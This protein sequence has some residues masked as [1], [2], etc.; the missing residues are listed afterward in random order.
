MLYKNFLKIFGL[1]VALL[2]SSAH[3]MTLDFTGGYRFEWTGISGPTLGSPAGDKTY[4]LN[5]LY[6]AP[7]IIAA[8]GINIVSRFDVLNTGGYQNS[9]LGQIWGMNVPNDG[10]S[11]ANGSNAGVAYLKMSQLY[12]SVEQEYGALL[13]GRV[14]IQF[15]L[16]M[17][18]N[19]GNGLFDHWYD[20]RDMVAYKIVLG[21]WFIMPMGGRIQS[22]GFYQG[23]TI[24]FEAA[25]VQ[26]E[27]KET[28]SS[29]GLMEELR[30]SSGTSNDLN[31]T[32]FGA[33][34]NGGRTGI[35]MQSTN[36]FLGRGFDNF[37][38]KLEAGFQSGNTGLVDVNGNNIKF[39][40]YGAA[41]ELN[42]PHP[43]SKWDFSGKLGMA[44]GENPNSTTYGA[45]QFSQN[46]DLGLL[47][48][49]HRLGQLDF[50]NTNAI[51]NPNLTVSNSADDEAIGNAMYLSPTVA[52]TFNDHFTL[53][54]TLVYAQLMQVQSSSIDS[55][56][57]L[58]LE[59]DV[60]LIYKPMERLQWINQVGVLLPG[61][62]WQN[63]DGTTGGL[64]NKIALGYVTKAAIS[65]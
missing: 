21:D 32:A 3:A 30:Q 62:A 7:K 39:G 55:K 36:F 45:Y 5:Y 50:L 19:A 41:V 11:A 34:P 53:V 65:F 26:Y 43:E 37:G 12:L 27:N 20:T 28:K 52:Y 4:G 38:F 24:S 57:D 29:L 25:Q 23:D 40:G 18:Y 59:W 35:S 1:S 60:T 8:D 47:L 22:S 56:K 44:S 10:T 14:P 51:K 46:Y 15:G 13:V 58:G 61:A 54:N 64:E 48:F 2:S 6:I 31:A 9:Y 33:D 42:F 63:G 17:K 16:G 49:N